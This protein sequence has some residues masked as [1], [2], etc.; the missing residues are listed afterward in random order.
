MIYI[1]INIIQIII[2]E[3]KSLLLI[4]KN[5]SWSRALQLFFTSQLKP[6][7]YSMPHHAPI[8]TGSTLTLI[9]RIAGPSSYVRTVP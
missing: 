4:E 6:S 2:L 9:L 8:L 3:N 1:N 7:P 5:L